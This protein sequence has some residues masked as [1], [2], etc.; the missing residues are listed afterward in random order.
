MTQNTYG[1]RGVN[2]SSRILLLRNGEVVSHI[3][4]P[5]NAFGRR[6]FPPTAEELELIKTENQHR[7]ALLNKALDQW[8]GEGS[9]DPDLKSELKAISSPR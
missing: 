1:H 2:G 8:D 3:S 6:K 4:T 5:F 9:I 7:A